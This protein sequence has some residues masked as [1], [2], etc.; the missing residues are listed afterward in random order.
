M[1]TKAIERFQQIRLLTQKFDDTFVMLL[2]LNL[3]AALG[4]LCISIYS[5]YI[6]EA[7]FEMKS[8]QIG[9]SLAT[10]VIILP[11]AA[12]LHAKVMK[13]AIFFC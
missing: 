8:A 13:I 6:G 3:S 7:T 10:L 12:G 11:P 2:S 4:M 9:A 5:I 1:F